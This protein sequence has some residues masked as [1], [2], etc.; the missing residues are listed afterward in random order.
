MAL[1]PDV[2]HD[3]EALRA[4]LLRAKASLQLGASYTHTKTLNEYIVTD[5]V[6]DAGSLE[7]LVIYVPCAIAAHSIRFGRRLSDFKEKFERT[8]YDA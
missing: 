8:R 1:D 3:H 5:V 6:L 2:R 7:P 4:E